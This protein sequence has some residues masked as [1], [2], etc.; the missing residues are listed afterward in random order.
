MPAPDTGIL[1]HKTFQDH[2]AEANKT[3]LERHLHKRGLKGLERGKIK[4]FPIKTH[5]LIISESH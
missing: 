4:P 2:L 5:N 1:E 3:N